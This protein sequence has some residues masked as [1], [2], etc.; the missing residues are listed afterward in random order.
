[1]ASA[2]PQGFEW[3]GP[4]A[5]PHP[6][7][8]I[9]QVLL[10]ALR[11][12]AADLTKPAQIEAASG[13]SKTYAELLRDWVHAA[14]GWRSLGIGVNDTVA[15]FTR[16]SHHSYTAMMGAV[17]EGV[18]LATMVPTA[19][20]AE[21]R[22]LLSRVHIRALVCEPANIQVALNVLPAGAVLVV[23][24]ESTGVDNA[25][26]IAVAELVRWGGT[27]NVDTYQAADVGDLRD[28]VCCI[29]YSSGTTGLPKGVM[30]T[31]YGLVAS[32]LQPSWSVVPSDTVLVTSAVSWIT[33]IFYLIVPVIVGATRVVLTY[34]N[35]SECLDVMREH[36]VSMLFIAPARYFLLAG[37]V[38]ALR[39]KGVVVDLSSLRVALAGGAAMSADLQKTCSEVLGVGIVQAYGCTEHLILSADTLP[40]R[41]G[42]AGKLGAGVRAK[43]VNIRTGEVIR[44]ANTEGE[45]RV[46]S[47]S[48]MKGYIGDPVTTAKAVDEDGWYCTGDLAKFDEEGR[49]FI[50]DRIKELLKFMNMEMTP[51]EIEDVLMTHPAV[52]AACVVGRHHDVVGDIPTAFV[53]LFPGQAASEQEIKDLVKAR[54]SANKQLRGGV[55]FLDEIPTSVNGKYDRK[56][57]RDRL[58]KLPPVSDQVLGIASQP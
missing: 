32:T 47:H 30:I 43:L 55:F 6:E 19:N 25:G 15:V 4:P 53:V 13:S 42:S 17:L 5:P 50:T 31:N 57:L 44:D 8:P 49:V 36:K 14:A 28:H 51:S 22:L 26:V 48:Y 20:E 39:K 33:G 12:H 16:N 45:M 54:L 38:K 11:R 56:A 27:V 3:R 40:P 23:A 9:G 29:V 41:F 1:M 34:T 21:A 52:R 58:S 35:E 2:T 18:T 10:D 37:H 24:A 7:L 46:K